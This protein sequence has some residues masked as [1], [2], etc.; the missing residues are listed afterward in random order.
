MKRFCRLVILA[1]IVSVSI[2]PLFASQL[3]PEPKRLFVDGSIRFSGLVC[4][5]GN[6]AYDL[7]WT[8]PD[9]DGIR[10]VHFQK[11]DAQDQ[12]LMPNP[13]IVNF[14][15]N[16]NHI[17]QM[18]P[19]PE[20]GYFFLKLTDGYYRAVRI[21]ASGQYLWLNTA[22][23]NDTSQLRIIPDHTGGLWNLC[24]PDDNSAT[25]IRYLPSMG[26][27]P[28][29]HFTLPADGQAQVFFDAKLLDDNKLLCLIGMGS[30]LRI[31]SLDPVAGIVTQQ[32]LVNDATGIYQ[33]KLVT[34]NSGDQYAIYASWAANLSQVK[35]FR[36]NA[37]SEPIWQN[38]VSLLNMGILACRGLDA[39]LL[40][41]GS[42]LLA[43]AFGGNLVYLQRF[44]SNGNLF[45]TD[46]SAALT[47]ENTSDFLELT[48]VSDNL[49][50]LKTQT[51]NYG[52]T[53]KTCL[54]YRIDQN[55]F[56]D[57]IGPVSI[58][59]DLQLATSKD[60]VS[61]LA[62]GGTLSF[63]FG[64]FDP[65][66]GSIIRRDLPASGNPG[67]EQILMSGS[68]G[69]VLNPLVI[70]AQDRVLTA[71][72]TKNVPT[73][74]TRINYQYVNPDGSFLLPQT[75]I[76]PSTGA[77]GNYS[78]LKAVA[79]D[80]GSVCL[81][82]TDLS[83]YR[84][85]MAQVLDASGNQLWGPYGRIIAEGNDVGGSSIF[86]LTYT[87]GKLFF[88]WTSSNLDLRMQVYQGSTPLH[89][90]SG[91]SLLN[92]S[93]LPIPELDG[94][95]VNA[96]E[97]NWL[98]YTASNF[99]VDSFGW[100]PVWVGALRFDAQGQILPAFSPVGTTVFDMEG[101][102]YT[103]VSYKRHM[104]CPDGILIKGAYGSANTDQYVSSSGAINW[105]STGLTSNRMD[106][107]GATGNGFF[108]SNQSNLMK[109]DYQHNNIWSVAWPWT[110]PSGAVEISPGTFIVLLYD[111]DYYVFSSATNHY[112][113]DDSS[114][115]PLTTGTRSITALNGYAYVIWTNQI[116][117]ALYMQKLNSSPVENLDPTEN[118]GPDL[119]SL[120]SYP[121]PFQQEMQIELE[122]KRNS[123]A[124]IEIYNLRG[125]LVRSL[126][127]TELQQG[128]NKLIWDGRDDHQRQLASGIYFV[129]AKTA[130]EQ[131][132]I[133]V[134]KM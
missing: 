108:C 97:G 102:Y 104:L 74:S 106:Y 34:A 61:V 133:K 24:R 75:G 90:H 41:D 31:M 8:M 30:Q 18:C 13:Q 12:P 89:A 91:L 42:I 51:Y 126:D 26:H 69:K 79:M 28:T 94:L 78:E 27:D 70:P 17:E 93:M 128:T 50:W 57:T 23:A 71:W 82:W 96:M 95:D 3:W 1:L 39:I 56:S 4:P 121:N 6:G 65:D 130:G 62:N 120:R 88:S 43:S 99:Y 33:V 10:K 127:H 45:W 132:V 87:G 98:I 38:P 54:A 21:N 123:P 64:R 60:R 113:P 115:Y 5:T 2:V 7:L 44:D 117:S 67:A 14:T 20:G 101:T 25:Y 48:E 76:I 29:L 49:V 109:K 55:G 68:G 46:E 110:S 37:Q 105:G 84:K 72:I 85:I 125:Q 83:S 124:K 114:I 134:L 15:N 59:Q 63:L 47:G 118:E 16:V 35:A 129:M 32:T 131:R 107:L 11:F 80:N 86:G 19:A 36:L 73:N 92:A 112:W 77:A 116:N 9:V 81:A 119:S 100:L 103:T 52:W 22:Y 53:R 111:M 40:T 122:C 66:A 58:V